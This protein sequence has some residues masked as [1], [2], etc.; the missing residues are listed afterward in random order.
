MHEV[1]PI[2][3]RTKV[4]GK[5]AQ[6]GHEPVEAPELKMFS[7]IPSFINVRFAGYAHC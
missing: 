7:D 6:Q 1:R 4:Q 3:C 5:A 2:G